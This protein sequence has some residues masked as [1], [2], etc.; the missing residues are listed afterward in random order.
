MLA[1]MSSAVFDHTNGFGLALL[2][3]YAPPVAAKVPVVLPPT[4][5]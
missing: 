3:E 5:K 4:E 1:R 2:K